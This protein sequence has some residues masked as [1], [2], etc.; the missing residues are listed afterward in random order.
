M[1]VCTGKGMSC[2]L[3]ICVHY[4]FICVRVCVHAYG[5]MQVLILFIL[6]ADLVIMVK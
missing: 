1:F 4:V 3:C 6:I 2:V 5:G